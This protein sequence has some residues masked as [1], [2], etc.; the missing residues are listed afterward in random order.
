MC[1]VA[2]AVERLAAWAGI[3]ATCSDL[4]GNAPLMQWSGG[5]DG[6]HALSV[7][8]RA[9]PVGIGSRCAVGEQPTV[10]VAARAT[11]A[12]AAFGAGAHPLV[13]NVRVADARGPRLVV[14][15]GLA[16]RGDPAEGEEWAL[17]AESN[18]NPCVRPRPYYVLNRNLDSAAQAAEASAL[19]AKMA[20]AEPAGWITLQAHLA[21]ECED[22]ITVE[23]ETVYVQRIVEEW[24]RR[25]LVQQVAYGH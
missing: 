3:G 13:A 14:V 18:G 2:G 11:S 10:R 9:Q 12:T 23:G 20:H 21:L 8:L 5:E 4:S 7:L 15:H 25:R 19:L 24:E 16:V 17:A 6:L 22:C 1:T